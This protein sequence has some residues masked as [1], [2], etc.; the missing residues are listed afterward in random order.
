M[1]FYKQESSDPKTNAQRNLMGRTHYVDPDALRFHK[2]RV[3][4]SRHVDNGLLFAIVTSDA[5]DYHNTKRGYRYAIFDLNG[6]VVERTEREGAF[7][8]RKAAEKA[9]WT[10]INSMN[11]KAL[12]LASIRRAKAR[13]IAE[14]DELS[15]NVTKA[16]E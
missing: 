3:L 13:A 2:S 16:G 12:N 11:A 1:Q 8:S 14:F 10:A 6:Y 15:D 4:S 5:L 7:K 9:M